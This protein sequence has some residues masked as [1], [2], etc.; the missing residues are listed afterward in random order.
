[1]S[2]CGL[3]SHPRRRVWNRIDKRASLGM[4]PCGLYKYSQ[5]ARHVRSMQS[6]TGQGRAAAGRAGGLEY[7]CGLCGLCRVADRT[8]T[9]VT[10]ATSL[11][12]Y[13][14]TFQTPMRWWCDELLVRQEERD[15]GDRMTNRS[16]IEVSTRAARIPAVDRACNWNWSCPRWVPGGSREQAN[17]RG[18]KLWTMQQHMRIWQLRLTLGETAL[19]N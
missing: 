6:K 3:F 19:G 10:L 8:S 14:M 18:V 15:G 9:C 12:M 2:P 16:M 1:M 7:A 11:T 5:L 13:V 17:G 4:L